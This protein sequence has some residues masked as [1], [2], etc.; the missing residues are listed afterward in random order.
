MSLFVFITSACEHLNQRAK[1]PDTKPQIVQQSED[2]PTAAHPSSSDVVTVPEFVSVKAPRV[3]VIFGPGGAKVLAQIGALQELE[4]Q[5]IPVVAAVGLEWGSLIGAL[6]ALNGQSHEVDWKMSQLP[7]VNFSGSNLFSKKMQATTS[8][9]YAKY[10]NKIFA[11]ERVEST[12]V[13]FACSYIKNE[14]ASSALITKGVVRN[15]LKN[16][17]QYPPLFSVADSHAAPYAL[18]DAVSYL[19][20]HGAELIVLIN[21]LESPSQKDFTNWNDSSWVW[22]SWVPVHVALKTARS[23]GVHETINLDTSA[24]SMID[25]DQRLRL[26]QVGK[27]GAASQIDQLIKKYDF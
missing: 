9:E 18:A 27:Q 3:G 13:P 15:V 5:K 21:V 22:F 23:I 8:T 16:C 4:R 19:K 1:T 7:K 6:Y 2:A 11:S 20:K 24:F 10:L 17:W 12:K 25:F 14:T 26:I